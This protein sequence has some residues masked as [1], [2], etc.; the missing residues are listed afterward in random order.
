MTPRRSKLALNLEHTAAVAAHLHDMGAHVIELQPYGTPVSLVVDG[1]PVGVRVATEAVRAHP[2][3]VGGK[4]YPNYKYSQLKFN[5][6]THNRKTKGIAVWVLVGIERGGTVRTYV[7]PASKLKGK[8]AT[9]HLG[10]VERHSLLLPY[11]DEWG[12]L[13]PVGRRRAA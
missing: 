13:V 12:C 5:L 9:V 6:H 1:V 8:T 4:W 7:V 3:T 2:V 11:R 10:R